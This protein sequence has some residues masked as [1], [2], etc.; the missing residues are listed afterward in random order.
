MSTPAFGPRA[1]I[2]ALLLLTLVVGGCASSDAADPGGAGAD[3][4][5]TD[6]TVDGS[7]PQD[8]AAQDPTAEPMDLPDGTPT[9]Q[10]CT[11]SF[12]HGLTPVYGRLDGLLVS[13]VAPSSNH[14]CNADSEHIHLQILMKGAIYDVAVNAGD[15]GVALP[16]LKFVEVDAPGLNGQWEEGWHTNVAFDYVSDLHVHST[17]FARVEISEITQTMEADL[18]EVNHVSVYATGYGSD[19]VHL[20]HRTYGGKDGAVVIRP[21]SAVP[22]VLAFCFADQ[23]F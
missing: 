12:G 20:V 13:I 4:A 16:S 3:D 17:N 23:G 22:R 5:G 19:G 15:V 18:A 6:A 7:N 8:D 21:L 10:A 11:E 9:R 2:L 14:A 1:W